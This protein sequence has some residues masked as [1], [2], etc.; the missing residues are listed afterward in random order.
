MVGNS[1]SDVHVHVGLLPNDHD[2]TLAITFCLPLI[3]IGVSGHSCMIFKQSA[4]AWT[5]CSATKDRRDASQVAQ[6]TVGELSLKSVIRFLWRSGHT[7]L[8]TSHSI[9]NPT[10]LRLEFE[11]VPVQFNDEIMFRFM[12]SDH[13]HQKTTGVHADSLPM[14]TPPT[15]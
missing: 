12:S 8:M 14:T 9:T 10:I 13:S 5:R 1:D 6:L 15:P 7:P 11:I 4:R 2:G 3:C